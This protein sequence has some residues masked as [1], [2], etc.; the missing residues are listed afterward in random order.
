[1]KPIIYKYIA[2]VLVTHALLVTL[3]CSKPADNASVS[4]D[5]GTVVVPSAKQDPTNRG[6]PE[7]KKY[8]T[9][10]PIRAKYAGIIKPGIAKDGATKNAKAMRELMSEWNPVGLLEDQIVFVLGP[11]TSH[12]REH[13]TMSYAFENG[14]LGT[15][16]KFI[17]KQGVVERVEE[18]GIQ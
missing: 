12:N 3:G 1:M 16:W 14:Y 7:V 5:S 8:D 18:F 10:V 13:N 11:A 6:D 17:F 2:A 4:E 15:G 9:L